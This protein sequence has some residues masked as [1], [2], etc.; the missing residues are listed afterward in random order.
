MAAHSNPKSSATAKRSE[1]TCYLCQKPITGG[2]SFYEDHGEK[3][4]I[5]CFRNTPR[6]QKCKFPSQQLRKVDGFGQVC[7]FCYESFAQE[8]GMFC[9]L[10]HGKIWSNASHYADHGKVVCQQCFKDAKIRCFSCRFPHVVESI[11]GQGGVCEFCIDTNLNKNSQL[12]S[13]FKPLQSFL[14]KFGHSIDADPKLLWVNWKLVLGMQ[15]ESPDTIVITF[16]DELVRYCYPVYYMKG[17]YYVIP[18][19]PRQWFMPYMAGQMVAADI[20]RKY[21]LFH[22]RGS[23]PF[24]DMARGWCHWVSYYTAKTLKYEKPKKTIA[25]WP[26]SKLPGNFQKFLAMSDFRSPT[27]IVEYAHKTLADYAKRYL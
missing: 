26:E 12:K 15:Q 13:M 5:A 18:S 25:R 14:S 11:P 3:I 10:C 21:D 23:S 27:E 1:D 9:Y 4:C 2:Q 8:E 22:L 20:C 17:I 16:F 19:I 24:L 6:C 7:E